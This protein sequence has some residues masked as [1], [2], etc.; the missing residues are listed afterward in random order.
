MMIF[1]QLDLPENGMG[2]CIAF[3]DRY[4]MGD[5]ITS[6]K[7]QASGTTRSI[8]RQHS[9]DSHIHGRGVEGFKHNLLSTENKNSNKIPVYRIQ[10]W[11]TWL[12]PN[13][14]CEICFGETPSLALNTNP[15][16]GPEVYRN[17]TAWIVIYILGEL[18][19]SNMI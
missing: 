3:I 8:Q 6:I 14:H 11:G 7:H 10:R 13:L 9:L 12:F 15:V 2:Q 18:K 4:S 5:T 19:I 1:S 17:G 16:V